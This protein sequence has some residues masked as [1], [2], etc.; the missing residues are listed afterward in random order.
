[1]R[2]EI[3]VEEDPDSQLNIEMEVFT[4]QVVVA[5]TA[6]GSHFFWIEVHRLKK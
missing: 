6:V 3:F 1:M 5:W 4:G 2:C